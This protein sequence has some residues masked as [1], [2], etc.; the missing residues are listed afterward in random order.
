M[1]NTD[2]I[3]KYKDIETELIHKVQYNECLD[4]HEHKYTS[5]DVITICSKLY[6]DELLSVFNA[7]TLID[8][9]IDSGMDY[10]MKELLKNERFTS[11]FEEFVSSLTERFCIDIQNV[12][13][14]KYAMLI[15]FSEP[16]FH[17]THKCIQQQLKEGKIDEETL[18]KIQSLTANNVYLK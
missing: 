4:E 16:L 15:L 2:F 1:Y 10:V 11:I 3:V 8:D 18:A 5:D 14:K 9:C 6:V 12:D 7:S 13:L 17:I